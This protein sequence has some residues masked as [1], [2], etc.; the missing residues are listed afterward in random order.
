M[1]PETL[2]A[3]RWYLLFTNL[4]RLKVRGTGSRRLVATK[5]DRDRHWESCGLAAVTAD[6]SGT[7]VVT[8]VEEGEVTD[9]EVSSAALYSRRSEA[10]RDK[11]RRES[12][13]KNMFID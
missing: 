12:T 6:V 7:E 13:T 1:S 5:T 8:W 2:S 3:E 10:L 11:V 9:G 4:S